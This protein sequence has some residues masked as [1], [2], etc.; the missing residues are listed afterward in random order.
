VTPLGDLR[1]LAIE[2]YGAGPFGSLQLAD[3]GA[4]VIRIETPSGDIARGVPPHAVDDDSLFYQSFNRNKRGIVLDLTMSDGREVFED[5]VR[6]SDAV[7]SNLRGDVVDTLRLRYADLA[8]INP[9]IVCCSVSGFGLTGPRRAEPAFDYMIQA[10]TGWMSLTGEPDGPPTKSGLSM[11]DFSAGLAGAAALLAGVHAARRDGIGCDCDVSLYDTAMSM[12][13]YVGTWQATAGFAAERRSH[14]A[15]P[16]MTPFQAFP[17]SDGWIVAGGTKEKFWRSMATAIERP[18]MA[19]DP[20][21]ASFATRRENREAFVSELE[22]TFA[23]RTSDEWIAR[24]EAAGVPCARVNSVAEALA[25]PIAEAHGTVIETEHPVFGTVR[26]IASAVRAGTPRAENVRAPGYGEH[27]E[28]VLR[29][30]LGYSEERV[31]ELAAAGA[32]KLS[33]DPAPR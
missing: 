25:E 1:I 26:S 29:E 14:S 24:L 31:H 20:R 3:L 32:V 4:D 6:V 9:R 15:H 7:Y 8:G 27:T 33:R 12:L 2:Q 13:N 22:A 16:T 19:E 28:S 11:V 30:L 5:L 21:F 10:M 23:T 17:T 18:D